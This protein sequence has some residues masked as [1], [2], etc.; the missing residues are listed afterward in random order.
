MFKARFDKAN[1]SSG[2]SF[3][4]PGVAEGLEILRRIRT[5]VGVPVLTDV[6]TEEQAIAAARHK[7]SVV[8]EKPMATRW[9]DGLRM[10]RAC[11]EN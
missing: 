10:V 3:R 4:G 9:D 6:H 1:R 2:K 8:T 11:D 5:E 7:V